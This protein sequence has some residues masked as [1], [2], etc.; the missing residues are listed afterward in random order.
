MVAPESSLDTRKRIRNDGWGDFPGGP[1]VKMSP[2]KTG[3]ALLIP[4]QRTKILHALR[5]KKPKYKAKQCSNK[6]NKDF[7]NGPLKKKKI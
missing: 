4:G 2:S 6:F 7:K 1:V 3:G 5:P